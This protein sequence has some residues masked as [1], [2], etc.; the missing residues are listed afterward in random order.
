MT[1]TDI[2]AKRVGAIIVDTILHSILVPVLM[3][4]ATGA[5]SFVWGIVILFSYYVLLEGPAGKGQTLGKKVMGIKVTTEDGKVPSYEKSAIRTL[6]RPIDGFLMYLPGTIVIFA[7]K[8]DQRLGD[9]AAKTI[10]VGA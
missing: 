2:F 4:F 8:K 9:I 5:S 10:V 6:L 3:I 7:T 1:N